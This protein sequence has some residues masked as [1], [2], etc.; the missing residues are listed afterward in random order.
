MRVSSTGRRP[1][2][3]VDYV[4]R[5][6]EQVTSAHRES[7]DTK[8]REAVERIE[9]GLRRALGDE[10]AAGALGQALETHSGEL[11]EQIAA[12]FG[13]DREGAVQAQIKRMLDERDEEFMRRLSADDERNPLSPIHGDAPDVGS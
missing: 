12:T 1:A 6:F 4:R 3:E 5:E 2:V 7:I 13:E 10:K 9:E 8:N 11:A